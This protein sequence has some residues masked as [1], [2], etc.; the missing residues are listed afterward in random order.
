MQ[1]YTKRCIAIGGFCLIS[2]IT[3]LSAQIS[4]KLQNKIAR[5]VITEIENVSDYRFFYNNE[6]SGL[7]KKI[8]VSVKDTDIR[9]LLDQ[10]KD[11][12]GIA[13]V[14]KENKQIVLSSA[15]SAQEKKI[16]VQGKVIDNQG[17]PIIGANVLEKGT[18][19]G[20]ITD[21]D[22]NFTL[23]VADNAVLQISY[24]GCVEENISV[25]GKKSVTVQLKEDNKSLDEVIVVAF[26]TQKKSSLTAAVA[27][28]DSKEISGRSVANISQ[29]LQGISPGLNVT[30]ANMGGGP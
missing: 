10:I 26:G 5:D 15:K 8:S 1:N 19:N 16:T 12:T 2:G 6:L 24:I 23:I 14:I 25:K 22:G 7:S 30:A 27:T 29:A 9:V 18:T 11:Q 28:V 13:Y 17:Q 20:T 3:T 21:I 4:L